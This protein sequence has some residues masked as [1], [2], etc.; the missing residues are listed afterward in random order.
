MLVDGLLGMV[1][2]RNLENVSRRVR[3]VRLAPSAGGGVVA[4]QRSLGERPRKAESAA[5]HLA[6]PQRR[7]GDHLGHHLLGLCGRQP[8]NATGPQHI[9]GRF[10]IKELHRSGAFE[11]DLG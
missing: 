6:P 5:P 10:G 3:T 4:V 11:P 2:H 8:V 1:R 7:L 9:G